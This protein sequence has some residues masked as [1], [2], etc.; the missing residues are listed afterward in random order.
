MENH[1][2]VLV[3]SSIESVLSKVNPVLYGTAAIQAILQHKKIYG[4]I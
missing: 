1:L 3:S 4:K 2:I